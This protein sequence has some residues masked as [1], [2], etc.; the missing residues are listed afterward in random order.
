M[1]SGPEF[2]VELRFRHGKAVSLKGVQRVIYIDYRVAHNG[3][4]GPWEAFGDPLPFS[5]DKV[6]PLYGLFVH[7][8]YHFAMAEVIGWSPVVRDGLFGVEGMWKGP[9]IGML[10]EEAAVLNQWRD[11]KVKSSIEWCQQTVIQGGADCTAEQMKR[12]LMFG[13][14]E[15]RHALSQFEKHGESQHVFGIKMIDHAHRYDS[16]RLSGVGRMGTIPD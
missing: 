6:H 1:F 4:D 2:S 10:L 7:D 14:E 5:M 13:E 11:R 12:A 9:D 15:W 8:V 3:K 16:G